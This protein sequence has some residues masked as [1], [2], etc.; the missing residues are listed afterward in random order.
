MRVYLMRHGQAVPPGPPYDDED[1]PLTAEGRL[2]ARASAEAWSRREDPRPQAWLVSPLV[3]AVQ[4]GEIGSFAFGSSAPVEIVR[5]LVPDGRVSEVVEAIGARTEP[6]IALVGH[7]P[8]LGGLA[9]FLLGWGTVPAQL[10]P[11]AILAIDLPE[12][13]TPRLAWHCVPARDERG[14]LFLVPRDD[15]PHRRS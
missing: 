9:A 14:P 3:R 11:G 6:S 8:L 1:R 4:T 7:Q 5:A 12:A 15:G 2:L 13:G 10:E